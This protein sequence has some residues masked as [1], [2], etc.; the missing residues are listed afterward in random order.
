MIGTAEKLI[1]FKHHAN[2]AFVPP[3]VPASK[4]LPDWYKNLATRYPE[5]GQQPFDAPTVKSCMPF[6]DALVQGYVIPL[7]ADL[8]VTTVINGEGKPNP[9]FTWGEAGDVIINSHQSMQTLGV[10]I[11]EQS[12][13][14]GPAF[15]FISPWVIE[16]PKNYSTLFVPPLNNAHPHFEVVSAI[17]S[18]DIYNN[19]INFPFIWRGPAD[20]EGV[21]LRGTPIVQLIPFKRDNFRHDISAITEADM[22]RIES[23]ARA[24]SNSFQGV[25]KQLWRK[26]GTSR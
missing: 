6:F 13:G 22:N 3:I 8:Y 9:L 21:L 23:M 17:V 2:N 1:K 24:L 11:M 7:W 25:Y 16:T 19:I 14:G 10:P 5:Q 18:T 12:L 26:T 4:V 15:K 20:W